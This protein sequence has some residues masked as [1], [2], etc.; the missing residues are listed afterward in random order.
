M[1]S[2]LVVPAAWGQVVPG[3]TDPDGL[4]F[5]SIKAAMPEY[6][7][8][9]GNGRARPTDIPDVFGPGAVLT[10]GNIFMKVTN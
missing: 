3:K 5:D 6:F 2:A 7:H 10:V 8:S 4:T 1:A 9:Y